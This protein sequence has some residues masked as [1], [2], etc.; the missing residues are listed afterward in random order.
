MTYFRREI[1]RIR[2]DLYGNNWQIANVI[3]TRRFLCENFDRPVSLDELS[4]ARF[5]SKFHLLRLFKRYYGQTPGQYLTELRI[6]KAKE[7]LQSG[8]SVTETC[9]EVGF[10]SPASFSNLFRERVGLAPKQFQKM[11]NIR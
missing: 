1:E 10:E 3:K 6:A 9:F 7:L 5:T 8:K 2:A 11:S 4:R